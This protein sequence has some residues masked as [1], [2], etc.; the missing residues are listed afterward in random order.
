MTKESLFRLVYASRNLVPMAEAE[1]E[2]A[3]ILAKARRNNPPLGVTGALLFSAEA[4]VQALEGGMDAVEQ[5][6]E[7]IQCDL[8]H[9]DVVVLEAGAVEARAF[10]AWSMAYAG[11]QP[12]IRFEALRDR[13]DGNAPAPMELLRGALGRMQGGR[14]VA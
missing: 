7:R 14:A 1:A 5:V 11:R 8:R 2:I 13:S 12:D 6:F 9:T 4:F 3:D 10:A